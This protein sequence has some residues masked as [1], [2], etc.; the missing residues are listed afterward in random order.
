ML[1][2]RNI[3]ILFISSIL[4][5]IFSFNAIGGEGNLYEIPLKEKIDSSEL[6]ISG[7]VINQNS[8]WDL[9]GGMIYT[10][11][12]I[13]IHS[14][15][16]GNYLSNTVNIITVGGRVGNHAVQTSSLLALEKG[17]IGFFF[18]NELGGSSKYEVYASR[19]GFIKIFDNQAFCPFYSSSVINLRNSIYTAT[20]VNIPIN[21]PA[22]SFSSSNGLVTLSV[23]NLNFSPSLI[24]AGTNSLVTITGTG[25]G[26]NGPDASNYIAFANAD[27]GGAPSFIAPMLSS[28]VSWTDNMIVVSVP[29]KAGTG[30]I[31][32][33]INGVSQESINNLIVS[34]AILNT[35]AD[36]IPQMINSNGNGGLTWEFSS[37][38][39]FSGGPMSPFNRAIDSWKCATG[40]NWDIATAQ[41]SIDSPN[42]GDGVNVVARNNVAA[43]VL[44]VCYNYFT[45]CNGDDWHIYGQ[46]LIFKK[47]W[48]GSGNWNYSISQPSSSEFDFESVALHELGH[49]HVLG[50][51]I[52]NNDVLHFALGAGATLRTLSYENITAGNY[53]MNLSTTSNGCAVSP[54]I[55]D[56]PT[57]CT[58]LSVTDFWVFPS[59][60]PLSDFTCEGLR[61][62]EISFENFGTDTINQIDFNWS[63]NGN[64]QNPVSYSGLLLA[65]QTLNDFLIGNY[66]FQ[67]SIYEVKIWTDSVNGV[68]DYNQFN[69]SLYYNFYP[70]QCSPNN[71]AITSIGAIDID[72]CLTIEDI[73]VDLFND[74]NNDL[75]SCWIFFEANGVLEDSLYWTGNLASGATLNDLFVTTFADFY[76]SA[77]ISIW[78]ELPNAVVDTYPENDTLRIQISPNRLLG[79]YSVGGI[80]PDFITLADAFNVLDNHGV[81]GDVILNIRDGVYQETIFIDSISADNMN[82]NVTIQ[83][84]GQDPQVVIIDSLNF[85]AQRTHN[86]EFRNLTFKNGNFDFNSG[87]SNITF[88][89]NH[90][91]TVELGVYMNYSNLLSD[92]IEILNNIFNFSRIDGKTW[93][94]SDT[95]STHF[96]VI[97]NDFYDGEG[98]AI[99]ISGYGNIEIADNY[100]EYLDTSPHDEAISISYR[101]GSLLVHN[102]KIIKTSGGRPL[103][104]QS[105]PNSDTN[106]VRIYNNAIYHNVNNISAQ[107]SAVL[108]SGINYLEFMHNTI[109]FSNDY[110]YPNTHSVLTFVG[111]DSL[112]IKSNMIVNDGNGLVYKIDNY[113]FVESDYNNYWT[114]HIFAKEPGAGSGTNFPTLS[115][116]SLHFSTDFNSTFIK[117][118]F[119]AP[120]FLSPINIS[121]LDNLGSPISSITEDLV[122]SLRNSTT[123][124]VGAYEFSQFQYDIGIEY[125]ATWLDTVFCSGGNVDLIFDAYNNG[126]ES[127]DSFQVYINIENGPTDT[128]TIYEVIQPLQTVSFNAGNYSFTDALTTIE[129]SLGFPNG[130]YDSIPYNNNYLGKFNT[131]MNGTYSVGDSTADFLNIDEAL[132]NLRKGICG[133]VVLN[134]KP[135][136]YSDWGIIGPIDGNSLTNSITFQSETF[137]TSSVLVINVVNNSEFRLNNIQNLTFKHITFDVPLYLDSVNVMN[138]DTC[139]FISG[140]IEQSYSS[141]YIDSLSIEGCSFYNSNIKLIGASSIVTNIEIINNSFIEDAVIC[142]EPQGNSNPTNILISGN[143]MNTVYQYNVYDANIYLKSCENFVISNND[144][145]GSNLGIEIVSSVGGSNIIKNNFLNILGESFE[146]ESNSGLRIL[147]N[148]IRS[149]GIELDY[150]NTIEFKNNIIHQYY[151]S[152][153]FR[154]SSIAEIQA[155]ESNNNLFYGDTSHFIYE[156]SLNFVSLDDWKTVHNQDVNSLY[157]NPFFAS[158][159]NFHTNSP[160]ADSNGLV[161]PDVTLD[162]DGQARNLTH[163]DIGADEFDVNWSLIFDLSADS[164]LNP[165][166]LSC[167]ANDS[168]LFVFSNN[169]TETLT[170]A[171]I[172][173]NLNGGPPTIYNWNGVLAPGQSDTVFLGLGGFIPTSNYSITVSIG[174]PNG[175]LDA[176]LI[177]NSVNITYQAYVE[178]VISVNQN[179]ICDGDELILASSYMNPAYSYSWSGGSTNDSLVITAGGTYWLQT[180]SPFGCVENDT[181]TIVDYPAPTQVS[182]QAADTVFC[183]D[184]SVILTAN[185]ILTGNIHYWNWTGGNPTSISVNA[186]SEIILTVE[187]QDG[188]FQ[189]DTIQLTAIQVPY[190][191]ILSGGGN[192]YCQNTPSGSTFQWYLDGVLIAGATNQVYSPLVNGEYTLLITNGICSHTTD[193]FIYDQVGLSKFTKNEISLSPNPATS[194]I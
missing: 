159:N 135:G 108:I 179:L 4:S 6:I 168:I 47:Y 39:Y 96:M 78:T 42:A 11:S 121:G 127:I 46:D 7:E 189:Y 24:T 155:L 191:S 174:E 17:Q 73:K 53:V 129:V 99:D 171:I 158:S 124:D 31:Q 106:H 82:Y 166:N 188:C 3:L 43:G 64:I 176:N 169:H 149:R 20:Q 16:K 161:L 70:N 34:Y 68:S 148:S 12:T 122:D 146:L 102:N 84:E 167:E 48:T 87:S 160:L 164:I 75:T 59:S 115:D 178:P 145:I 125:S 139:R 77:D 153:F 111:I 13:E 117:P 45:A 63:V 137:D 175:G 93:F 112:L 98:T 49:A 150:N 194:E 91:D 79:S 193:A 90:F 23:S 76:P 51:I 89:Q 28:Y 8:Y 144:I 33:T 181:V 30:P 118:I 50:H 126:T 140:G 131:K 15:F 151:A 18:L 136:V 60:V 114:D 100:I 180:I 172:K 10:N 58:G 128:L 182:I 54:M 88:D 187:D 147:N 177:N 185:P 154:L 138:V 1:F 104:I 83:S 27:D 35:G 37:N 2:L 38:M 113:D 32:V 170:S 62:V 162:I 61:D 72:S 141:Q 57:G 69:D 163:P 120:Y 66:N 105:L 101:Y 95:M 186:T 92:S 44:G 41:T 133:P 132:Y 65:G 116:F 22:S 25:F 184:E 134:L 52:D 26:T 94:T 142:F 86:L 74:G 36:S 40:V 71:A 97:N 157:G 80:N 123:P 67:D 173:W 14:L 55:S 9:P 21:P 29:T 192:L 143:V 103:R 5:F 190:T 19:Q 183:S 81:C 85:E 110:I 152:P 119:S 109:Y 165:S 56:F 156:P 107:T 130:V